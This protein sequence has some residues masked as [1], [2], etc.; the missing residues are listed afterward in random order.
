[1]KLFLN[2]SIRIGL[3]KTFWYFN[4]AINDN[5]IENFK[6]ANNLTELSIKIK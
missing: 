6:F 5:F 3:E 2:I 4:D 1:M